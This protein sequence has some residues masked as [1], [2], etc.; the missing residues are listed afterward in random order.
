MTVFVLVPGMFTGAHVWQETADRL[1]AAGA[2]A[3]AVA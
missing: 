1:T 2:E 3:H